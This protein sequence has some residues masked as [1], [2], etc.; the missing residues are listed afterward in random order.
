MRIW[1]RIWVS[2]QKERDLNNV[3]K[4]AAGKCGYGENY[5]G[6]ARQKRGKRQR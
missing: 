2:S 4:A 3:I 5:P 6:N 1:I